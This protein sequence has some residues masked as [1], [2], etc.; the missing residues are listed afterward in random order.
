MMETNFW[1]AINVSK[2]AVKLMREDNVKNGGKTGGV[3]VN[4]TS[5]GGRVSF[6]GDAMYHASKYALEA[7]TEALA[8]EVDPKWNISFLLL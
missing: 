3:I 6:G 8:Q 5:M 7:Y 4:V 2:R 1:A